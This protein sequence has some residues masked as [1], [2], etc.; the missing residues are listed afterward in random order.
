[1]RSIPRWRKS[2]VSTAVKDEARVE[3]AP[4]ARREVGDPAA[5]HSDRR[6]RSL[7]G[8]RRPVTAPV[9]VAITAW[10]IERHLPP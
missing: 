9:H 1:M 10:R 7:S 6:S 2:P 3:V 8:T 4:V 5:R